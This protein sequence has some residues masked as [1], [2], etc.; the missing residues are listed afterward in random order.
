MQLIYEKTKAPVEIGDVLTI[1]FHGECTVVGIQEP[2]LPYES[3]KVIARITG[4]SYD[5]RWF[6]NVIGARWEH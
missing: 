5:N 6:P 3:G 4:T 1:N 2:R